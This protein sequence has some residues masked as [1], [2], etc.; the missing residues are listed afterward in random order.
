MVRF[1]AAIAS[2]V[3][4]KSNTTIDGYKNYYASLEFQRDLMSWFKVTQSRSHP[5]V[6]FVPSATRHGN[7]NRVSYMPSQTREK[8]FYFSFCVFLH[9]LQAQAIC[10]VAGNKMMSKFHEETGVPMVS[11]GLGGIM[12]PSHILYEAELLPEGDEVSA[13]VEMIDTIVPAVRPQIEELAKY[14]PADLLYPIVEEEILAFRNRLE[15]GE[16]HPLYFDRQE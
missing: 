1:D 5:R 8:S 15:K 7:P 16:V 13:Y 2:L 10:K 3:N 14:A 4:M 12:H 11:C 6:L 9:T